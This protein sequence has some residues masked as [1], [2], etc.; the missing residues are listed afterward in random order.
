MIHFQPFWYFPNM[1]FIGP[2]VSTYR[3]SIIFK[4]SISIFID[5]TFP[6]PSPGDGTQRIVPKMGVKAWIDAR[7]REHMLGLV[8]D[9]PIVSVFATNV[10]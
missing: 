8:P 3:L 2:P 4:N 1:K 10:D 7:A 6:K 5:V 9:T